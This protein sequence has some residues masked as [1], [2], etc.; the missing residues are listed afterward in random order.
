MFALHDG[1]ADGS[2]L[3]ETWPE[4]TGNG[5]PQAGAVS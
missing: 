5:D 4:G 3:G 1:V 2:R